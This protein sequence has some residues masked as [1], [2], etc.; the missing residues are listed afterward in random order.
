M[1]LSEDLDGFS[2]MES[3]TAVGGDLSIDDNITRCQS[4]GDA[5]IAALGRSLVTNG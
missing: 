5:F 4:L 3:M 2:S 1:I